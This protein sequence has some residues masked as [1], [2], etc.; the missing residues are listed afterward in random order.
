MTLYSYKGAEPAELPTRLKIAAEDS[1]SGERETRTH[2]DKLSDD[3]LKDLDLIRV[4]LVEYDHMEYFHE[5]NSEKCD[6]DIIQLD[7]QEKASRQYTPQPDPVADWVDFE[8]R[9]PHLQIYKKI[10]T[11]EIPFLMQ[12]ICEVRIMLTYARYN[13]PRAYQRGV[14]NLQQGIDIL[15][16][17]EENG[18]TQEDRDNFLTNMKLAN[19]DVEIN[20]PDEE[21][22]EHH[23][24]E[25]S[26]EHLKYHEEMWGHYTHCLKADSHNIGGE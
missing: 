25:L 11:S 16:V 3:E 2:L 22:R 10:F 9:F 12:F 23:S 20:I 26:V 7:E 4:D 1:P 8:E 21:W 24:F 19:L 5:W 14:F 6:Y 15:S 13:D 17:I 18:V